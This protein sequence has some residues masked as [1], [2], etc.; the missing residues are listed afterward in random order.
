VTPLPATIDQAAKQYLVYNFSPYSPS[1]YATAQQKTKIK[2]P[3]T[4]VPEY[5]ILDGKNSDGK[6]DPSKTG[7]TFT[8]GPY[9]DIPAGA[10]EA[11]RARYEFTKP[12]LHVSKLE[13]DVE[14]SHWGGNLAIEERYWL[15]NHAANLKNHFSRLGWAATSYYNPATSALKELR[16]PLRVGATNPYFTDDIGNVSTSRFRSNAREAQLEF[17]P[18]YPVFGGWKYSFRVG[19]DTNLSSYLRSLSGGDGYILKVPFIEGP[20]MPEGIEYGSVAV[21][22]ILP[23]GAR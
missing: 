21:R 3:S 20:K 23:E 18:R 22:I 6:E 4:D 12:V 8:Y 5:T 19:W 15:E 11:A 16:M 17:K 14:V 7:S 2:F 9:T 13:R 10:V 1:T